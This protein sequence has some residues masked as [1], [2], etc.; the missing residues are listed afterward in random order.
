VLNLGESVKIENVSPVSALLNV[1][2]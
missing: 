2:I 1:S